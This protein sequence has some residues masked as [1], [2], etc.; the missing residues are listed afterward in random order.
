[1]TNRTSGALLSSHGRDT[2]TPRPY[3]HLNAT[4]LLHIPAPYPN[5]GLTYDSSIIPRAEASC[6][7]RQA[8][9]QRYF[10]HSK[11]RIFAAMHQW[12]P[13]LSRLI[14]ALVAAS[15]FCVTARAHDVSQSDSKIEIHGHEV[16]VTFRLNLLEL[17]YVDTNGDGLISYDELDNSIARVYAAVKQHYLLHGPDLPIQVTLEKYSVV[18]GHVVDMELDYQFANDVTK[19]QV[20]S[21]LHQIT[22]PTHEHL[23]SANLNGTVHEAVLNA[24]NPSTVF[25]AS[26]SA[27]LKTFGNFVRLGIMHI[28]TGYDHL[29]FLVGLLIVTTNLQSL[30]KIITSFTV[31]HSITL[32]LATFNLVVI[33]SRWTESLIALSIAYVAAENIWGKRAVERYFIAFAFGLIHGFGFSNVLREM[34]LARAHLAL[35]LFS[36]NLGVEIG[37]LTF[38]L[39]LFPLVVY[40]TSSTWK[41]QFQVSVSTAV[42]CLAVYWF[43]QRAFLI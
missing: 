43:M 27:T 5:P 11:M 40:M 10:I 26:D 30:I 18:E 21:T 7:R 16:H 25:A 34:D 3:P 19:L 8:A 22:Q 38:V 35:S 6:R 39:A 36:F 9:H 12:L 2:R 28:F 23:T 42:L 1:M 14:L 37:Q 20:T 33:P 24:A 4:S 31:A 41:R 13:L 29:A 32:A 17:G 15:L